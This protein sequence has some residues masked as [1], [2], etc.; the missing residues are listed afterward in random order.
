MLQF[1]QALIR[2][3]DA[4]LAY[5][6]LP[7]LAGLSFELFCGELLGLLGPNGAGKTTI[8]NCIAAPRSSIEGKFRLPVKAD[9]PTVWGSYRKSLQSILI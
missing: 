3:D 6:D 9:C 5:G 1:P 2:I 8:I 4:H 7:A